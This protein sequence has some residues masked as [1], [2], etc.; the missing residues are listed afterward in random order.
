LLQSAKIRMFKHQE[1]SVEENYLTKRVLRRFMNLK[2]LV[3]WK[4]ADDAMLHIIGITCKNLESIDLWISLKVTDL[5]MKRLLGLD[6][7]HKTK[8]CKTIEKVMIKDTS[9][10]N[11]GAF[12]LLL[13][14]PKLRFFSWILYKTVPRYYR[15]KLCKHTQNICY[16][17]H[18]LP[19]P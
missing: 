9:V 19:S 3:L 7:Q 10:T 18:V 4:A 15:T 5:G 16:Q 8:L 11:V 1:I 2:T 14:C 13:H 6:T 17:V 12:D